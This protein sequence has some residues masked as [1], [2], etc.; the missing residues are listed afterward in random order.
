MVAWGMGE[1]TT[2]KIDRVKC[3]LIFPADMGE[4]VESV[5]R[6]LAERGCLELWW[7]DISASGW[8]SCELAQS[9]SHDIW[10]DGVKTGEKALYFRF[11]ETGLK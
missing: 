7:N 10:R 11:P 6:E 2:A 4:R 1:A 9:I 3:G 8:G 5:F